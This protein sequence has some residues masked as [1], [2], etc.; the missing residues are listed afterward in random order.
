M[1]NEKL[2]HARYLIRHIKADIRQLV[3]GWPYFAI[4][5]VASI[6]GYLFLLYGV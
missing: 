6:L 1:K 5:T 3:G 2:P 4:A